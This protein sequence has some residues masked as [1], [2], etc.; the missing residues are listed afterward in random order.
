M[1]RNLQKFGNSRGIILTS[2]ML[3]HLGVETSVDITLE[4]GKI[5]ITAPAAGAVVSRRRRQSFREAADATLKQYDIAL[6]NLA[7]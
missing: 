1:L 6:E 3:D 2:D 4:A 7:K 5:V